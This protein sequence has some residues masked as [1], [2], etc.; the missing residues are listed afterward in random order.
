MRRHG[1]DS[2]HLRQGDNPVTRYGGDTPLV[3]ITF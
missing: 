1:L 2:K 3:F